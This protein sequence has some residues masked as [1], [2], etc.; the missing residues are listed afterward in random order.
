MLNVELYSTSRTW[1]AALYWASALAQFWLQWLVELSTISDGGH[2]Q[3]NLG[4]SE[5]KA[6]AVT[7]ELL[8]EQAPP[9][10]TMICPESKSRSSLWKWTRKH[11][12]HLA[13]KEVVL[14]LVSHG[15]P[16]ELESGDFPLK[17]SSLAAVALQ[18]SQCHCNQEASH[19]RDVVA[20]WGCST[21]PWSLFL[22]ILSLGEPELVS[23]RSSHSPGGWHCAFHL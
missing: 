10:V 18:Q 8:R 22:D 7:T 13:L 11:L 19:L 6:G 4:S 20:T 3:P 14:K 15:T 5:C 1:G 16:G 21:G 17:E 2:S 12:T 9:G 23:T